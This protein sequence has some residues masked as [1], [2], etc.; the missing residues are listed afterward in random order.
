M[1]RASLSS[2]LLLL[3]AA[4]A[5]C[6]RTPASNYVTIDGFAQGSTYHFVVEQEDSTGLQ[7]QI[8]S[9]LTEI[10]NSLSVYND[11][12][13]LSRLNRGETDSLDSHLIY[14]IEACRA[15]SEITDG[16]FD[17]TIKPVTAAWGFAGKGQT[18]NPNIDSLMQFVGYK[19]IA[20]SDNRLVREDRRMQLDLNTSSQ[21]YTADLLG[22][23]MEARGSQNYLVEIGGEVY[24]KG[25]NAKGQPWS[26]GVDKPCEGNFTPGAQLQTIIELSSSQGLATSGNYRKYR[27]DSEG[28]KVAHI[29]DARTGYSKM[30]N[31]LSATVVA[32]NT[33]LADMYGTVLM[34][35]G[36]EQSKAF[37]A[38]HP[39][40]DA[41]LVYSDEQGNYQTYSTPNLRTREVK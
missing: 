39:E 18:E 1:N 11:S 10:D 23:L 12:S 33:T 36:L 21:G 26:I 5:S 24:C 19:R 29:I 17:I 38:A 35:L 40:M 9:V 2:F 20:I 15:V 4:T 30:S 7:A 41:L 14:N 22:Q 25:V 27:T 37:L 31:L 32:Q 28:R 3:M 8:D 34:I 6:D 16:S 13:L